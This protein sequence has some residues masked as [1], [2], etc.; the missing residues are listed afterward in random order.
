MKKMIFALTATSI[1]MAS[2]KK[3][4]PSVEEVPVATVFPSTYNFDN[5]SYTGQTKRL[6]MLEA[7]T[8]ELKK[9]N[10]GTQVDSSLLA[11]MY[12]NSGNPFG[13]ASLD[14]SG[15]Q[16]KNKEITNAFKKFI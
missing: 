3:D 2:C 12:S 4:E 14:G 11:R 15:K 10:A 6:D 7:M 5:V 8:A 9:A 1:M 13:D 16:L